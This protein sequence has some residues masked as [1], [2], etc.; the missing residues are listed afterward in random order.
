MEKWGAGGL[1]KLIP[2]IVFEKKNI[3]GIIMII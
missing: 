3:K 2:L 1:V